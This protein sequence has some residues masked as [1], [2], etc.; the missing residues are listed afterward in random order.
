M[1]CAPGLQLMPYRRGAQPWKG[2]LAAMD[3]RSNLNALAA[4][5]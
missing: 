3:A 1:N 4:V 5:Y 2:K